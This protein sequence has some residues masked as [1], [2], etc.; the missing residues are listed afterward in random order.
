M[1]S[2]VDFGGHVGV[3]MG[4][5]LFFRFHLVLIFLLVFHL[6]CSCQTKITKFNLG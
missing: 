4:F 6:D 2:K 3:G 5:D 1:C